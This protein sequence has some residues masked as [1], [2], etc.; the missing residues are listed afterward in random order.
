MIG[1]LAGTFR[2]L[3]RAPWYSLTVI[4]V[5]ALGLALATTVFA[6]V[7]GVLFRPLPYPQADHL[8]TVLPGFTGI[9][10]ESR[11]AV[12]I[13]HIADWISAAPDVKFTGFRAQSW[14]G[15]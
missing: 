3:R 8:F 10:S 11:H 2:S 7:D 1:I 12:G 13:G 6:I 9:T 15:Y 14:V 5:M 4:G